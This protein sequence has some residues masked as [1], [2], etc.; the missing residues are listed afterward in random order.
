M[1]KKLETPEEVGKRAD[2]ESPV[3]KEKEEKIIDNIDRANDAAERLEN[4]NARKA[5][6]LEKE[7]KL[8]I[9]RKLGGESEAG[10]QPVKPKE[11]TPEEYAEKVMANEVETKDT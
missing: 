3:N 7:E 10:A 11:D 6:L 1:N 4:A 9:E 5:E 8:L 2:K